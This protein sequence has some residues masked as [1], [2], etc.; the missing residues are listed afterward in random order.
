MRIVAIGAAHLAFAQRVMIRQAHLPLLGLMTLQASVIGLPLGLNKR[1]S[2]RCEVLNRRDVALSHEIETHVSRGALFISVI[3]GLMA[4]SAADFVRGMWPGHPVADSFIA[5]VAAQASTVRICGGT[6][7]ESD[8]FG[9]ITSTFYV[10]ATRTMT[11]LTFNALLGMKC[12]PEILSDVFVTG[13]TN[14][15]SDRFRARNFYE[16]GKR[17]DGIPRLFGRVGC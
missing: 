8:N 14:L 7:P 4:I 17:R 16:P 12:M 5:S 2:L 11:L 13:G 9:N 10:Q 15:G 3:V 6:L 1:L